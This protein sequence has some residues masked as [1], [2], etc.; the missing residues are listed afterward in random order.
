M[1]SSSFTSIILNY[2]L[3]GLLYLAVI[4]IVIKEL[5][6]ETNPSLVRFIIDWLSL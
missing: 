2:L 1:S 6:L 5:R 3:C 4:N